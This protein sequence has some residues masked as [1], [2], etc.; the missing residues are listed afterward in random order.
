MLK[1]GY[2]AVL[3]T[4]IMIGGLAWPLPDHAETTG[5]NNARL[6]GVLFR[7][8]TLRG[9]AIAQQ[10][11]ADITIGKAQAIINRAQ[12]GH[13]TK[14]EQIG[15]QALNVAL[16]TRAKAALKQKK[17][18][19]AIAR[20]R[21]RQAHLP[22]QTEVGAVVTDFSGTSRYFSQKLKQTMPLD[23]DRAGF[24]EPGDEI[25][26]AGDGGARLQMADGRAGLSL[27]PNS[28]LRLEEDERGDQVAD[29]ME[30][31]LYL[32]VD[33]LDEYRQKI[34]DK[35]V[36]L[37]NDAATVAGA[38]ISEISKAYENLL[39]SL[40]IKMKNR[41]QVRTPT[42]ALAVRG[43]RFIV[44]ED[45]QAGTEVI[46]LDGLVEVSGGNGQQPVSI[47]G[48]YIARIGA[49]GDII[50]PRQTDVTAIEPWW[51]ED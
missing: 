43:T 38:D 25:R 24:L 40:S 14:A 37:K 34:E 26:T 32:T 6:Q 42:V 12:Q 41:F 5:Y 1:K 7:L 36:S 51:S 4:G 19:A 3:L 46:V 17:L 45:K 49:D 29:L 13:N 30:G 18:E 48:G 22:D 39:K 35:L 27:G 8:E 44:T 23:D 20:I 16:Q 21:S 9:D 33:K 28:T 31:K 15:Q 47:P 11:K 2:L 10:Q 50:G